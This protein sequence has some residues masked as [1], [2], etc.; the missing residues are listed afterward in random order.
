VPED[1]ALVGFDDMPWLSEFSPPLTAVAQPS[2]ELGQEAINL[3]LRR[4]AQPTAPARTVILQTRLIIRQSCGVQLRPKK[5]RN[6]E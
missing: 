3:L 4:I 6:T 2:Y 5:V 1:I